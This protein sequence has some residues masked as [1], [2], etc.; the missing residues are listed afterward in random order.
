MENN[1]EAVFISALT[2]EGLSDFTDSLE[3]LLRRGKR[4]IMIKLPQSKAGIVST[5]YAKGEN[6]EVD[7]CADGIYAT[8]MADEKLQGQLSEYITEA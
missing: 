8:L 4:Q 2:G 5:L 7:Y 3:K 1:G 6:V